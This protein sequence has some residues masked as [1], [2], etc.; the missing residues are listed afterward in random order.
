MARYDSSTPFA[1]ISS[2]FLSG[3]HGSVT[4]AQV[5]R[6]F[7]VPARYSLSV[8]RVNG[9]LG[10]IGRLHSRLALRLRSLDN[11]ARLSIAVF[12]SYG[13]M[14]PSLRGADPGPTPLQRSSGIT[15]RFGLTVLPLYGS[16]SLPT[17]LPNCGSPAHCGPRENRLALR[18]NGPSDIRFALHVRSFLRTARTPLLRSSKN[19]VRFLHTV[20]CPDGSHFCH[21]VLRGHGSLQ[22]YGPL[23]QRLTG[24]SVPPP[25]GSGRRRVPSERPR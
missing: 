8:L 14:S 12:G 24:V 18:V 23:H 9:S 11:T 6:S 1:I 25:P 10:F 17:V 19:A 22:T 20:L 16:H 13:S 2:T 21:T 15:V 7:V 4:N 5:I 3:L